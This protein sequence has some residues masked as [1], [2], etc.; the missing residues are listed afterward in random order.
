MNWLDIRRIIKSGFTNFTR[1]GI[2]SVASV[3][4][5]TIT[6]SVIMGLIFTQAILQKS[7]SEIENKVDVTIYFN[8]GVAEDKIQTLKSSI[9]KLAEVAQVDYVSSAQAL[10][11]FR[12][13]HENDYLTLQALDELNDN[14]LGASLNIKAKDTAQ[15]ES[16]VKLLEG[17]NALAKDNSDIIDKINYHQNKVVIDRLTNIISGARMMGIIVTIILILISIIITF[18]T[19]RLT[20]HYAREE[21]GIMRLVGAGNRYIR[22]PFMVEGVIYGV[23]AT[24][25]TIALYFPVTIWLGRHM[26]DFFGI[27]TFSYYMSNFFQIFFIILFSGVVLGSI[28]SFLAIRRYL[29]Q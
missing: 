22:G 8:T 20:I 17:D 3:L 5:V 4:V 15:Y 21:I 11:D 28:S 7:L 18:N 16:I 14:P 2:V 6:L 23:I 13:R 19:I 26:T 10:E 1:N 27:D 29:R 12:A 25:I 24:L 9:E